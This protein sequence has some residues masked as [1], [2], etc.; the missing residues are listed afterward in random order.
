MRA[1]SPL[2]L[3]ALGARDLNQVLIPVLVVSAFTCLVPVGLL[4]EPLK[5]VLKACNDDW[6]QC[7][8]TIAGLQMTGFDSKLEA[9]CFQSN[10][11]M[12]II[13]F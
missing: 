4:S 10:H 12:K 13:K 6:S 7:P 9:F 2:P 1:E 11:I 8:T 3:C 5:Y